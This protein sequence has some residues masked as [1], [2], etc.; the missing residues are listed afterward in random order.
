MFGYEF[1]PAGKTD[2]LTMNF[3]PYHDYRVRQKLY[4]KKLVWD[5]SFPLNGPLQITF[6]FLILL[7]HLLPGIFFSVTIFK[8]SLPVSYFFYSYGILKFSLSH[9]LCSVSPIRWNIYVVFCFS[10]T[11]PV[12]GNVWCEKPVMN[13]TDG[14]GEMH[15]GD[16]SL[17][18]IPVCMCWVVACSHTSWMS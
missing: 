1:S 14:C 18:P 9:E 10:F 7:Q 4:L 6:I 15:R 17:V 13:G 16:R 8:C 3:T 12:E 2:I 5:S 11:Y